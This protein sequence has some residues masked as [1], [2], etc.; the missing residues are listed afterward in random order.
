MVQ[1]A[2]DFRDSLVEMPNREGNIFFDNGGYQRGTERGYDAVNLYDKNERVIAVYKKQ[3]NGEYIFSTT[4][5]L[6]PIE[7]T[8][9]Y[10]STGNFVTE[11]V[12]KNPNYK[13]NY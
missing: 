5:K 6:T 7:E 12:L 3:E 11:V 1:N 9:L 2:L 13:D 10:K 4:C 8:H